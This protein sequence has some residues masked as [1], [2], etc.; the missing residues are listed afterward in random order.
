MT[1]RVCIQC[2][3]H[4]RRLPGEGPS[5][6]AARRYCSHACASKARFAECK[7]CPQC[8]KSFHQRFGEQ[9]CEFRQRTYCNAEC[10]IRAHSTA[11][12]WRCECGADASATIY[13][14]QFGASGQET[15][16]HL[17]VCADC[18]ALFLDTDPTARLEPWTAE[19]YAASDRDRN[20]WGWD[21]KYQQTERDYHAQAKL[22]THATRR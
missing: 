6:W 22:I 4:L 19:E 7:T 10:A 14:R 21:D 11:E 15:L 18:I 3:K 9:Q 17:N 20:R 16:A 1:N 2:G 12:E 8:G 5:K 13:F